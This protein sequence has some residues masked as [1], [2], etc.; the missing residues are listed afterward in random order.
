ME[1]LWGI[2]GILFLTA[3]FIVTMSPSTG[4]CKEPIK[5]GLIRDLTS[6]HAEAGRSQVDA[7]KMVFDEVNE[8]GGILGHKIDYQIGDEQ[9]SPDRAASL[10]KRY[11]N[12]DKV[13]LIS[14]TTPHLGPAWPS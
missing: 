13:L 2:S 9:A 10:A 12:V 7:Q 8:K 4:T 11:I 5:I 1:R 6:A 14:G 3:I